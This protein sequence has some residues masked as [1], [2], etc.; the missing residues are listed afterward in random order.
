MSLFNGQR[1]KI[2]A[3]FELEMKQEIVKQFTKKNKNL[4]TLSRRV[5]GA[6]IRVS[7]IVTGPHYV[8]DDASLTSRLRNAPLAAYFKRPS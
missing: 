1:S 7:Y 8:R 5:D 3:A 4:Q 6:N 2:T